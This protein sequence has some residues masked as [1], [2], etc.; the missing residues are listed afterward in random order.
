MENQNSSKT[1]S[2]L[3][4]EIKQR[5]TLYLPRYSIFDLQAFYNG[6]IVALR[7]SGNSNIH[8]IE[9]DEFLDWIREICPVK[10]NHSWANLMFFYATDERDALDKF[11]GLLDDFQK[12]KRSASAVEE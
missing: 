5:P 3:L 1:F 2:D 10:T 9:F 7:Q 6:Y 8:E 4:E 12:L 11:F